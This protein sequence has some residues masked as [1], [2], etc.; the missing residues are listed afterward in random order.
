MEKMLRSTDRSGGWR[1]GTGVGGLRIYGR[2]E[3]NATGVVKTEAGLEQYIPI[4]LS[5][6]D[7]GLYDSARIPLNVID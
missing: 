3:Q 6:V 5:D 7:T 4:C 2:Q 1:D